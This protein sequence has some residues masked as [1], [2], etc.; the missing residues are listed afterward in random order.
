MRFAWNNACR[1][2]LWLFMAQ[3]GKALA[4]KAIDIGFSFLNTKHLATVIGSQCAYTAATHD[5]MPMGA[6]VRRNSLHG[7]FKE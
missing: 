7:G 6:V 4:F 1:K 2:I 5:I 3:G